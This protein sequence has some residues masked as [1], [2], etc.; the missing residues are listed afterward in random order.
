MSL[1]LALAEADSADLLPSPDNPTK[2]DRTTVQ[3][4]K[5]GF[6]QVLSD[7]QVRNS[8]ALITS[9]SGSE[10]AR[11]DHEAGADVVSLARWRASVHDRK[12]HGSCEVC[13]DK[14]PEGRK[15]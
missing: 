6:C 12:M 3:G 7:C 10:P 11:P 4:E 1:W 9:G 5:A 8:S 13:S 15:P 2:P 14:K